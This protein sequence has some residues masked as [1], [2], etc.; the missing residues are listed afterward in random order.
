MKIAPNQSSAVIAV[1]H[2]DAEPELEEVADRAQVVSRRRPPHR[3]PDPERQDDRADRREPTH[4]TPRRRRG[5]RVPAAPTVEPP[6]RCSRRASSRTAARAE[7]TA[8]DE[9]I[10]RRPDTPPDPDPERD[11]RERVGDE[12]DQVVTCMTISD[13]GAGDCNE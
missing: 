11:L 4:H 10:A 7:R 12:Q 1:A 5:S 3:R 2:P 6:R 9:E 8:G 13:K